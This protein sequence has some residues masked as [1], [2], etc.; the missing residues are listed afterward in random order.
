MLGAL[1][2]EAWVGVGIATAG[3]APDDVDV[4]VGSVTWGSAMGGGRWDTDVG[5]RT[6]GL[7]T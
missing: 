3:V 2:R 7:I 4:G 1:N 5:L 6:L